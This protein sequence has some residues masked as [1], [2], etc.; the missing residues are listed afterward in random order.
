M[1]VFTALCWTFPTVALYSQLIRKHCEVF[2]KAITGV[3]YA[4]TF[5]IYADTFIRAW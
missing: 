2:Q 1:Y 3:I 5:I 4:D